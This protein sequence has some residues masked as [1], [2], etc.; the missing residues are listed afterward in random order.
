MN[1]ANK[2]ICLNLNAQ[3]E[4][5][6]YKTVKDAII[7]LCGAEAQGKADALAIDIDYDL[8][9]ENQPIFTYA[10]SMR[11]VSWSEW[12]TL[13]IRDWEFYISSPKQNIRVPT[14]II[15][16]NFKKMPYKR[17]SATPTPS[18]VYSR[19]SGICQYTN[20]KLTREESSIDHII[21]KSKGGDNSWT[22]V[23]L[24]DKQLNTKK[25]NRLNSE[26]GLTP[27]KVPQIPKSVPYSHLITEARNVDWTHF[28]KKSR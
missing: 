19:D 16:S 17:V 1:V 8:N 7:Q 14:V 20:R 21:P 13:P 22:N 26:I 15:S 6:G 9:S 3:W 12:I 27:I 24:C 5:T 28:L 4:P 18:E 11:P 25:G 10:K 2:L 23:V